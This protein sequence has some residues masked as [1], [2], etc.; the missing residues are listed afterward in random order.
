[1]EDDHATKALMLVTFAT[2]S[3][4]IGSSS[5]QERAGPLTL[6]PLRPP[7]RRTRMA[8]SCQRCLSYRRATS[9]M[10]QLREPSR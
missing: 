6:L 8:A 4:G 5:T 2:L 7:S 1:M 3:L 10:A 9:D